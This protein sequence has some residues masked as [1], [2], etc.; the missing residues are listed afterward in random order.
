MSVLHHIVHWS[1]NS[2]LAACAGEHLTSSVTRTQNYAFVSF[3][4]P[5][6][7]CIAIGK[8]VMPGMSYLDKLLRIISRGIA[9]NHSQR[10]H[11]LHPYVHTPQPRNAQRVWH[12]ISS[13]QPGVYHRPMN[14]FMSSLTW[15]VTAPLKIFT[16]SCQLCATIHCKYTRADVSSSTCA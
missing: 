3:E 8:E 5:E 14:P 1:M 4:I 10:H 6:L 7:V 11:V 12:E 16:L 13:H 15:E 2:C 9:L